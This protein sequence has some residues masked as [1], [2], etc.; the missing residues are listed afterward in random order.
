[1]KT[2]TLKYTQN[3]MKHNFVA[4]HAQKSGTGFHTTKAKPDIILEVS[5]MQCWECDH[6]FDG[7]S[8]DTCSKCNGNKTYE[9]WR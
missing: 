3:I 1:M 8:G 7:K 6:V 4:K 2:V 5:V 9:M